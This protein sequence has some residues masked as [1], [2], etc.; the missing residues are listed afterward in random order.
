M[1]CSFV[2]AAQMMSGCH[3][4]AGCGRE[5]RVLKQNVRRRAILGVELEHF[6]QKGYNFLHVLFFFSRHS[7]HTRSSIDIL[8]TQEPAL[9]WLQ[10]ALI[11]LQPLGNRKELSTDSGPKRSA[12]K[13]HHREQWKK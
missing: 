13:S 12:S 7:L 5:K 11:R 4:H 1:G 3:C 2:H 8:T 6:E 10:A 9:I